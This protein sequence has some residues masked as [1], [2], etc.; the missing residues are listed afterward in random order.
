MGEVS[1]IPD[2]SRLGV[3]EGRV[4]GCLLEKQRTT[5][6]LYPLTAN[7]LVAACNQSSSRDPV[8][9]LAEHDVMAALTAL[10]STGWLRF[11]HPS[12][13]RSV[14]RYRHI[15][16]ERLG[17]DD[18]TLTVLGLLLLRG[19]QTD[20][21]LRSRAERWFDFPDLG[22][23]T[24]VL[25]SAMT[26]G[27]VRLLDREPGRKEPRW[28][29]LLADEPERPS[30]PGLPTSPVSAGTSA[31]LE[32]LEREVADLRSQV[33]ALASLDARLQTLEAALHDLL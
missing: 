12:H 6:D 13:G 3:V 7:A 29:Q 15:V 30:G 14:T 32:A 28:Q 5:P 1:S 8:M 22:A 24:T 19:P 9:Q 17:V 10:K 16:D 27:F 26:Q 2:P 25:E 21:E 11:V 23:V 18:A 31:R 4:I 20:G 33:T